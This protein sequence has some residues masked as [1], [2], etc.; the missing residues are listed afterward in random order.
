MKL[1]TALRALAF[2]ALAP[3]LLGAAA[4]AREARLDVP[5]FGQTLEWRW[6]SDFMGDTRALIADNGCA[7]TATAMVL[8][9]WGVDTDPRRLDRALLL[10]GGYSELSYAGEKLGRMGMNFG[11]IPR[12]FPAIATVKYRGAVRR[13][14][15]LQSIRDELAAGRP[16]VLMLQS[17]GGFSH[18]VCATGFSGDDILINDPLDKNIHSLREGYGRKGAKGAWPLEGVIYDAISVYPKDP[19]LKK[20]APST[21]EG[22]AKAATTVKAPATFPEEIPPGPAPRMLRMPGGTFKMGA[23]DASSYFAEEPVHAVTLR[24]FMA[25]ERELTVGE[26]RRFVRDTG[27]L[28]AAERVGGAYILLDGLFSFAPGASW[29][30]PGFSQADDEPVLCVSWEDAVEYC[31]YLSL[32]EGL[33]PAYSF[34]DGA[35]AFDRGANGYRLPTEA[36][37]EFAARGAGKGAWGGAATAEDAGWVMGDSGGRS[38]TGGLK[39]PNARGLFDMTG[40][41]WEWCWDRFGQD[42]YSRSPGFDPLGPDGATAAGDARSARGGSWASRPRNARDTQRFSRFPDEPMSILGFRLFRNAAE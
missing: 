10:G 4:P 30:A 22:R 19:S 29:K 36:E 25:A 35:W 12:I 33:V 37:W 24:P 23:D 9:Y 28:T 42:Y 2:G 27:Y 31:V 26:F 17:P 34:K 3:L 38:R 14:A 16:V 21:A 39:A 6:G 32:R 18:S 8:S 1:R 13:D 15:D 5:Y 20:P 40:N 41:V 11:A 7:L